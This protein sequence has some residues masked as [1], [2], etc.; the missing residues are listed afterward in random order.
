VV[1]YGDSGHVVGGCGAD[2]LVNT[3]RAIQQAVAG[4]EMQMDKL[5]F[6]HREGGC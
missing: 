2:D 5:F 3:A 4:M 6:I 1:G